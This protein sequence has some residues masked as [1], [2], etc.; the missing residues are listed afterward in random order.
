MSNFL[1]NPKFKNPMFWI[2]LIAVIFAGA[3]IDMNTLTSWDL[4]FNAILNILNNPVSIISVIVA[5]IGVFNDN[6]TKGLDRI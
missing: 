4:F 6:S 2:S 1:K 5:I 3:D